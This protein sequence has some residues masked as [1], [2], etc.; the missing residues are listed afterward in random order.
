MATNA[1]V[2]A[3]RLGDFGGNFSRNPRRIPSAA[4]IEAEGVTFYDNSIRKEP[5]T[6][7]LDQNTS[8]PSGNRI[9]GGI[10]DWQPSPT[11]QRITHWVSN[12]G[13]YSTDT[14]LSDIDAL[15]S[16]Q[17]FG[18]GSISVQMIQAGNELASGNRKLFVFTGAGL[19]YYLDG[20]T[21]DATAPTP[22][23]DWSGGEYPTFG[24]LHNNRLWAGGN[25]SDPHRIYASDPDDHSDWSEANADTLDFGVGTG[26]GDRLWAGLSFKGI[27]FLWKNPKGVFW[28]DDTDINSLGWR[29]QKLTDSI[30]CAPSPKAVL[31]AD[32][33]IIFM[34]ADAT[35]HILRATTQGGVAIE[36]LSEPMEIDS[37]LAENVNRSRLFE[38][39]S[40]WYSRERLATF[41]VP[42]ATEGT[43]I[44]LMFDFKTT[45]QSFLPRFSYSFR[46]DVEALSVRRDPSTQV[47]IPVFGDSDG[48]II[49][50]EQEERTAT[51]GAYEQKART[52]NDDFASLDPRLA[53]R[54]K[55]FRFIELEYIPQTATTLT[56]TVFIDGAERQ[57]I[58]MALEAGG[59]VLDTNTLGTD[60]LQA[61]LSGD[62]L[63]T[64]RRELRVGAGRR[65]S[66]R[67]SNSTALED[68]NITNV[69][70]GYEAGD[71]GEKSSTGG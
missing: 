29:V 32:D 46:D 47:E 44:R 50:M 23:A 5:G 48:N 4:L 18:F 57:T 54:N 30:G 45:E 13:L 41:A 24:V 42:S 12:G 26:V 16:T 69:Y 25:T 36:P 68:A 70:I 43:H 37:F 38:V 19:P 52:P 7:L 3:L 22:P 60:A 20:D 8:A 64:C 65:I 63:K 17:L 31:Q 1:Q 51:T 39:E 61:A 58:S 21:K 59:F 28:L 67:F 66:L 33:F 53:N 49:I 11:K 10:I 35:F 9:I 6:V 56:V 62:A 34:A 14:D 71:E 15:L 55:N 40:V 2:I 27:L